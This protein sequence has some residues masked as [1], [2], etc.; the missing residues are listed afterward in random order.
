MRSIVLPIMLVREIGLKFLNSHAGLPALRIGVTSARLQI[1]GTSLFF[2][3][4]L[5]TVSRWCL[6]GAFMLRIMCPVMLSGPGA[7]LGSICNIAL[8]SSCS[9]RGSLNS[10]V[11]EFRILESLTFFLASLAVWASAVLFFLPLLS[12]DGCI[13]S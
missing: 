12:L 10:L 6:A 7:L 8:V 11:R 1:V 5:N 3:D 2:Q 4:M 9:V 13:V